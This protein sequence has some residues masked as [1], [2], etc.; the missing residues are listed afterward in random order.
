ML[1]QN[2]SDTTA[3]SLMVLFYFLALYPSH[4]AKIQKEL[5]AIDYTDIKALTALPHLD[6]TI[7]ESMRLLP[8]VPSWGSRVVSPDGLTLDGV[9]IPGGT[10]ICA[11]RYSIGRRE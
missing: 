3:S 6:A 1:M 5:E 4:A 8:S 10:K 9:F 7:N 11:P 2:T